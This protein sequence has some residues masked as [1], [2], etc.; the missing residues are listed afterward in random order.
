MIV[1]LHS[2]SSVARHFDFT[3]QPERWK[4]DGYLDQVVVPAGRVEVGMS[5]YRVGSR[6][7]LDGNV[8]GR[9]R[10]RC[11]RCLEYF[12]RDFS[13]GFQICLAFPPVEQSTDELE[14]S[15]EDMSVDFITG[16]DVDLAAIA[17]EQIY[18][19]MPM[20]IL[21]N[22]HCAGLC[23]GCGVNLNS[24]PCRCKRVG[25]PVFSRLERIMR[26]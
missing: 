12:E 7:V 15:E 17:R 1:D 8:A 14:L 5:I 21:C 3:L 23:P 26:H 4:T 25:N 13:S 16:D 9:L 19:A 22:E 24:E 11:D 6:F 18:L 2:I 10:A 20:K